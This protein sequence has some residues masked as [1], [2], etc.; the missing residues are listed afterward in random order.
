[1]S[2]LNVVGLVAQ[3]EGLEQYYSTTL[4]VEMPSTGPKVLEFIFPADV[5]VGSERA[6]LTVVGKYLFR[7]YSS[8]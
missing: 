8:T 1:M 5:V 7:Q 3:A 4:F 6:A 2:V